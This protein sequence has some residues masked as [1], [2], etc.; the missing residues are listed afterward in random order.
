MS[1]CV[2]LR[3]VRGT[4]SST[5]LGFCPVRRLGPLSPSYNVCSRESGGIPTLSR[6]ECKRLHSR[7]SLL[8]RG[9]L[10]K[11]SVHIDAKE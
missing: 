9:C 6:C 3:V 5:V 7:K 11:E 2:F 8:I 10:L 1:V 4:H